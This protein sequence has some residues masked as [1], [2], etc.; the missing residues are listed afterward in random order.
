[1]IYIYIY[2]YDFHLWIELCI[3]CLILLSDLSFWFLLGLG[4]PKGCSECRILGHFEGCVTES[5][6]RC[7]QLKGI[8]TQAHTKL[9][10]IQKPGHSAFNEHWPC[11]MF[12]EQFSI[13]SAML[14]QSLSLSQHQRQILQQQKTCCCWSQSSSFPDKQSLLLDYWAILLRVSIQNEN[15]SMA[16]PKKILL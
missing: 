15:G 6:H 16:W 7:L 12:S 1:M 8:Y 11:L 5:T 2:T 3:I 10:K 14:Q 9:L 13:D 4:R